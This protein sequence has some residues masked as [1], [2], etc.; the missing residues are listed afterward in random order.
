MNLRALVVDDESR[1]R[2][3]LI[4]LLADHA[5]VLVVG[6]AT[7]GEHAVQQVLALRPD[8]VFLDVQMPELTGTQALARLRDYLPQSVRPAVVFTTAYA[9]HAVQAFAL[10]GTDY[11]LKPIERDRLA[12]ALRRVRQ[13]RWAQAPSP[14]P[15]APTKEAAFLTGHHGRAIQSVPVMALL[16]VQVEDGTVWAYSVDGSKS[17]LTGGCPRS[18]RACRAPPLGR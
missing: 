8:L 9:E 13:Q 5:D 10:E 16:Y 2:S 1:A 12:E 7:D 6:E 4:R 11:L 17:R 18:K 3:R 15:V 14:A